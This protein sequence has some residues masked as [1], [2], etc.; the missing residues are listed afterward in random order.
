MKFLIAYIRTTSRLTD[1][2]VASYV[3]AQQR[4]FDEHFE[5]AWG[6]GATCTYYPP[7]SLVPGGV[8]QVF[9]QDHV[10]EAGAYGFHDHEGFP[11]SYVAVADTMADGNSWTVTASHET[12]EMVADPTIDRTAT[13]DGFEYAWEV[14]DAPEDDRFGYELDGVKVSAFVLPSWF[15][16]HGVAPFS[17]PPT[18]AIDRPFALAE[19]GYIG[20]RTLPDGQWDQRLAQGMPGKRTVKT[21]TSR[22]KRRFA[23]DLDMPANVG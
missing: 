12:L 16:P 4:Q 23:A 11:R 18:P 20:V 5:P 10:A 22:T 17:Y 14:C 19:G 21:D 13:V 1:A 9:L 6:I 2:E 15:D 3:A 8:V 7:G